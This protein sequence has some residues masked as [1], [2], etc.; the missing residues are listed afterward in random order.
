MNHKL[1]LYFFLQKVIKGS[2]GT[3]AGPIWLDEVSCLGNETSLDK[4]MHFSWGQSNCNHA[5]DV[6]VQCSNGKAIAQLWTQKKFPR[7]KS[8]NSYRSVQSIQRKTQSAG[9]Q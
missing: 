6:S 2:F 7:I 1:F 3:P 5:E 4:C 8:L 9:V